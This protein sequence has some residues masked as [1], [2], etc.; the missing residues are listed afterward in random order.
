MTTRR[1]SVMSRLALV[2]GRAA[3]EL[4]RRLGKGRGAQVGGKVAYRLWPRTLDDLAAGRTTVLVSATNGKSTTATLV[5]AA[6]RTLGTTAFNA[7]AGRGRGRPARADRPA[8]H[9]DDRPGVAQW[10]RLGDDRIAG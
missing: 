10:A 6:V 2:A 3:S 4:S 5:A 7:T 1:L 9:V 8:G